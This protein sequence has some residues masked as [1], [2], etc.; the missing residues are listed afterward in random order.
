[1]HSL[2]GSE[3]QRYVECF[4]SHAQ[5]RTGVMQTSAVASLRDWTTNLLESIEIF[6]DFLQGQSGATMKLGKACARICIHLYAL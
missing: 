3:N 4:V 5:P 1:M 6:S 2:F